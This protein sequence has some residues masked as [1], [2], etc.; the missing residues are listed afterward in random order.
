MDINESVP[1]AAAVVRAA[2]IVR[3]LH[4]NLKNNIHPQIFNN[5]EYYQL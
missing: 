5:Y 1:A 3:L 2:N 4:P